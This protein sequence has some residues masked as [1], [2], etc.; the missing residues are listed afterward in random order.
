[1]IVAATTGRAV[2]KI[3]GTTVHSAVLIPIESSDVK[4]KD[5]LTLAQLKAWKKHQ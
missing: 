4:R 1:L 3:N 2:V 5:K